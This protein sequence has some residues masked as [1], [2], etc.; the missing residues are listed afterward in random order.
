MSTTAATTE[1][2]TTIAPDRLDAVTGGGAAAYAIGYAG[3]W[4]VTKGLELTPW[5]SQI[6]PDP[7]QPSRR[8]PKADIPVIGPKLVKAGYPSLGAG[9]T[10]SVVDLA[11]AHAR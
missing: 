9:A 7:A 3:G 8:I 2:F 5:G 6:V 1:P 11:N 4:A 10:D